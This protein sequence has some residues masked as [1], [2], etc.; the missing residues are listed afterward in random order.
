MVISRTGGCGET[1]FLIIVVLFFAENI[2]PLSV[3]LFIAFFC[4]FGFDFM[5]AD[6]STLQLE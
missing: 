1:F 5:K 4:L 6:V 3:V 2:Q